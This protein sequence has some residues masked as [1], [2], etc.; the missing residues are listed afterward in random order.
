MSSCAPPQKKTQKEIRNCRS[1][2]DSTS[3]QIY[4][5]ADAQPLTDILP[6]FLLSFRQISTAIFALNLIHFRTFFNQCVDQKSLILS[7]TARHDT[8]KR[9]VCGGSSMERR[10]CTQNDRCAESREASSSG[11][12]RLMRTHLLQCCG[13][14]FKE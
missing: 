14:Q 3:R 10:K 8:L 4:V 7:T 5:C 12:P 2:T 11:L 9:T 1:E 13:L 6:M